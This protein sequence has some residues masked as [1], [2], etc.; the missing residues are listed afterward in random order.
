M[1]RATDRIKGYANGMLVFTLHDGFGNVLRIR[2][3]GAE[4]R[5]L[6]TRRRDMKQADNFRKMLDYPEM[7]RKVFTHMASGETKPA[8]FHSKPWWVRLWRKL[9]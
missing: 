2:E 4:V 5:R 3:L 6:E 8:T 7:T 9:W 1:S